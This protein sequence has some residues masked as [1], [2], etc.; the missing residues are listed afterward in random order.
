MDN[1][2]DISKLRNI[3]TSPPFLF[4]CGIAASVWLYTEIAKPDRIKAGDHFSLFF[5]ADDEAFR[6]EYDLQMDECALALADRTAR[7]VPNKNGRTTEWYCELQPGGF[8]L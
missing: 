1:R 7:A 3:L 4:W 6:A 5:V 8:K 2:M